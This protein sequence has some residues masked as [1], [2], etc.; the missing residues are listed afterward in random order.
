MSLASPSSIV[1]GVGLIFDFGEAMLEERTDSIGEE[2]RGEENR[3]AGL[4]LL[5]LKLGDGRGRVG[6]KR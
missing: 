1:F 3:G 4:E 6:R 2:R 5:G